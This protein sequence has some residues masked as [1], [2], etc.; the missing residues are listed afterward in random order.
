M[1]Y[2]T[3]FAHIRNRAVFRQG[4]LYCRDL[5]GS[6]DNFL[7]SAFQAT[8]INY[9]KFYKMDASSKL[10]FLAAE[11]LLK[12][13][14]IREEY[15]SSEV[16][17]ILA[18]A[19]ASLDTDFRYFES[20]K[21]MASPALFVYT[22]ANIVAGEICIRHG[23]KGENAFFVWPNFDPAQMHQYVEAVLSSP[24]TK[25]CIAGWVDVMGGQ[26]DVFLYLAEKKERDN[27]REHLVSH[28][29]KLY[30]LKEYGT[31]NG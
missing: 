14:S 22:L 10:G 1:T 11:M 16:A 17:V 5:R 30:Q 8:E 9:P 27:S 15:K 31:V 12:D 28:L 2:I 3:S 7:D 18:N 24:K 20:M 6:L 29:Q 25:A 26:H 4:G 21:T 13:I 23:I 19:H